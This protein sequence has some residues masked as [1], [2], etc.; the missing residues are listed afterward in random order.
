MDFYPSKF[1]ANH[2][3]D[4]VSVDYQIRLPRVD[5]PSLENVE[6]NFEVSST[7]DI[8]DSCD[9][10]KR[11]APVF[12][13]GDGDVHG[14]FAC[15]SNNEDINKDYCMNDSSLSNNVARFEAGM[16]MLGLAL[17]LFSALFL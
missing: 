16:E 8:S 10:L 11:L 3:S 4:Q 13:C 5:F 7:N 9:G 15:L 12:Q 14:T 17:A 2:H 6:G 1:S